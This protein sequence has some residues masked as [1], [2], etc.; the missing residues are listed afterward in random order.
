MTSDVIVVGGGPAGLAAALYIKKQGKRVLL[1]EHNEKLGKKL[2]ITGKGRCNVSN[3]CDMDEF[4]KQVP[5]NPRFLYA[6][7]AFLPPQKLRDWL[8]DLGCPTVVER[9]RRVFPESQ[10]ASDVTRALSRGLTAEEVRFKAEVTELMTDENGVRGVRLSSGEELTAKSVILATGGLSYPVTGSTG[11]GHQLAEKAGHTVTPLSPSLTGFNTRDQWPKTLQG[12]GLKN[13]SLNAAWGKK[14]KHSEQGE[15]LFTHFGISGP[16]TLTLSS[17]L[18]GTDVKEARV[19]LDLKP[20]LDRQTLI[21]RLANDIIA[22]GRKTLA[23]LMPA[24]LPASLAAIF[25][26]LIG[27]KGDKVLNQ[28]SAKDR[29]DIITGLKSL[30]IRLES[31]RAF[32]EAVV[33][34]GGVSVKEVNPST[35]ESKLVK[36]LYFAGEVLDVDAFT[37]GYNLQIA[38]STGAL[39]GKS[40]AENIE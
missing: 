2:Y 17:L 27:I 3:L 33:T 36:G 15:L 31:H 40:A 20:A 8:A 12:L 39:A 37:G 35:L 14:S 10:K 4:L 9:G 28:L 16:L 38:F 1:I 32:N 23:G 5:R 19:T 29:E 34:R 18:A 26:E 11:I 30:P 7:L 13:V 24:Y 6:S 21:S 25:P 22:Q